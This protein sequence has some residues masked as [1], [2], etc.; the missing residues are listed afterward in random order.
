MTEKANPS[1]NRPAEAYKTAGAIAYGGHG[2]GGFVVDGANPTEISVQDS[3]ITEANLNTFA[4]TSSGSSFD[5]DIDAGEAFVFG[6]WLAI[7]T[8]T[9]VTLAA[10]TAG[11]TVYVGWNKNGADDVIVGLA[12]DFSDSSGDSDERIPLWTFDTDGSGVTSVTDERTIGYSVE[13]EGQATFGANADVTVSYDSVNDELDVDGADLTVAGVTVVDES[14]GYIPQTSLENDDITLSAGT[15]LTGG[16]GV[17]LGNSITLNHAD[18]SSQGNVAA[19][20][21]AAVTDIDLN[22]QGHVTN[23]G[24]TDF[25]SRFVL[26][27]GDTMGGN[28]NL[29]GNTLRNFGKLKA[30]GHSGFIFAGTENIHYNDGS[31]VIFQINNGGPTK[32]RTGD[33]DITSG[34]FFGLPKRTS[35][36][37]S[38]GDMWYR[39]DLD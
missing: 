17:A 15:A 1:V 35:D 9:T 2:S 7:D 37:G 16:G 23:I 32:V 11:Q 13:V 21:G 12:A 34:G 6:S 25:D 31:N 30:D 29:N 26:E 19:G 4:E 36:G 20:A 24:T 10:S 39:T 22:P 27:S 8:S 33:F 14:Q 3:G 18:T 28:L 38:V 5:V